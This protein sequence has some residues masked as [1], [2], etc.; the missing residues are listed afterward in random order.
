MQVKT[1]VQADSNL[2]SNLAGCFCFCI[3]FLGLVTE[4]VLR[5]RAAFRGWKV[6]HSK[7]NYNLHSQTTFHRFI[8][9]ML[10]QKGQ[11]HLNQ[12][13]LNLNIHVSEAMWF[14]SKVFQLG[15]SISPA[16]PVSQN[17]VPGQQILSNILTILKHSET[18]IQQ[19]WPTLDCQKRNA[20]M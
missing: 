17:K 2:E 12:L 5:T 16:P 19:N 8:R 14:Y 1:E 18:P 6:R 15:F 4:S 3:S 11:C 10:S 13:K 7:G 20:N 9:S